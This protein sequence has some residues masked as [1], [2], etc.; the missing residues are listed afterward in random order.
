MREPLDQWTILLA[1][2]PFSEEDSLS[3]LPL[4]VQFP[5]QVDWAT[6]DLCARPAA[7]M[8]FGASR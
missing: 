1:R 6:R 2:G 7:T 4:N 8:P 5:G 3:A